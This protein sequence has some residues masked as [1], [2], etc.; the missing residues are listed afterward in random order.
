MGMKHK[1]IAEVFSADGGYIASR[2]VDGQMIVWDLKSGKPL[3]CPLR[4]HSYLFYLG[5]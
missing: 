3:G 4:G 5:R 1:V 2:D